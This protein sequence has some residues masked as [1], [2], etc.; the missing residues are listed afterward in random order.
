MTTHPTGTL[1]TYEANLSVSGEN[2]DH[3]IHV[4]VHGTARVVADVLTASAESF[5]KETER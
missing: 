1:P 4:T 3:F 5:R 2:G